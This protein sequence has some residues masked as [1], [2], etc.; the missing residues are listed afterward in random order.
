MMRAVS[1]TVGRRHHRALVDVLDFIPENHPQRSDLIQ[2]MHGLADTLPKYQDANGLG[3]QVLDKPEYEG[4]HHE[5][6]AP[7][8]F[9]YGYAEAVKKGYLDEKYLSVA[10]KAYNGLMQDLM[11]ENSDSTLTLTQC[12]VV[13]GLGGHPYRDGSVDYYVNERVRENDAKATGPF[14]TGCLYLGR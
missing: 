5:A 14:I 9:I 2:L 8:M 10:E 7:S 1:K 12:C 13:S 3:Y 6:S 11:V 4:N